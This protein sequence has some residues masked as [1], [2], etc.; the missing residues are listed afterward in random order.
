MAEVTEVKER[1]K[2][3]ECGHVDKLVESGLIQFENLLN[4]SS[5]KST[6]ACILREIKEGRSVHLSVGKKW[7]QMIHCPICGEKLLTELVGT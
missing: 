6:P 3:S 1:E 5:G 2:L 7:I 4:M